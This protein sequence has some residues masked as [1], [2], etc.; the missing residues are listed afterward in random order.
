MA[1]PTL[2][3]GPEFEVRQERVRENILR[4]LQLDAARWAAILLT[5]TGACAVEATIASLVPREAGL[6]VVSNG[7]AGERLADIGRAHGV[8]V[9]EVASEWSRA[10]DLVMIEGAIAQA[11]ARGA[12]P[13]AL[14][15]VHH[16]RATGL[17]NPVA[18]IGA[19]AKQHGLLYLL[20]AV[21]S[22][23]GESIDLDHAGVD[24]AACS[25]NRCFEGEAGISF[26][27]ARRAR[28]VDAARTERRSPYLDLVAHLATQDARGT[29]FSPAILPLAALDD[30]A[31]RLVDE[32]VIGRIHRYRGYAKT[33]RE[34]VQRSGL[35]PWLREELRSNTVT[36]VALP[37]G[38]SFER[39]R[40]AM[41]A[42]GFA[43]GAVAVDGAVRA[44]TLG[45]MGTLAAP[46]LARAIDVLSRAL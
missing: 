17:V 4:A 37:E 20:D 39:L 33:V 43:L 41:R 44:F 25:A 12:R 32:T 24:A 35:S 45:H 31:Q 21:S 42:E 28:I 23:G 30:A 40:D 14:A 16:E 38:A 26:V 29:L 6:I 1:L 13:K 10:P 11:N 34:G 46:D 19:L 8:D 15:A 3:I 5:G 2:L 36:A 22:L 18:A 9:T 27:V 7:P